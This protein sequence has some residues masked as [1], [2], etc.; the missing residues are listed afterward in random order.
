MPARR[1]MFGRGVLF[2]RSSFAQEILP[3]LPAFPSALRAPVMTLSGQQVYDE[4]E[5]LSAVPESVRATMRAVCHVVVTRSARQEGWG[6]ALEAGLFA[7][8]KGLGEPP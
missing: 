7:F 5:R 6:L 2:L 3:A 4:P 8:P 1:S